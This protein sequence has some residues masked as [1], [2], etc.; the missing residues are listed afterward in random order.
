MSKPN[1]NVF[2]FKKQLGVGAAGEK[3]FFDFYNKE[4]GDLVKTDGVKYDFEYTSGKTI[5]LK[6][7]TYAMD[8][9][10]NFFMERLG[11]TESKKN[12]GPWRALDDKVD[13]FV[14]LYIKDMVAFWFKTRR[15]VNLLNKHEMELKH[16]EIKNRTWT[17]L[18]YIVPRSLCKPV[19]IREDKI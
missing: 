11:N 5:E 12:G 7:D 4:K 10:P 18:G 19:L 2:D 14:Y 13:Y 17:T 3:A 15:L 6:T 9:T 1:D 8:K 16:R